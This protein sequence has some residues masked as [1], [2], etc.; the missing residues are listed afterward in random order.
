VLVALHQIRAE[1]ID[2]ERACGA[3]HAE[4]EHPQRAHYA[5][6]LNNRPLFIFAICVVLFQLANASMMPL[7]GGMLSH[8]GRSQAAPVIAALII[9]PQFIV[10]LL[11][12]R[13]GQWAEDYG[14]KPLLLIGF[15]VLPIRAILFAL[16]S[17]PFALI[18]I[19]ALDG[20][21][22]AVLGVMTALV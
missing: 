6:L 17:D 13:V 5:A 22:G 20:I 21:T 10:V 7:L 8:K 1:E 16:T 18:V 19:Q 15:A 11:A 3:E 14:R 2:F 12:P 9:V 4:A